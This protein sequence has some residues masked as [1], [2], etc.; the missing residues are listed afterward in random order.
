MAEGLRI[1][2]VC[3]ARSATY[4]AVH[5]MRTLGDAL[6]RGGD[7]VTYVTFRGRGLGAELRREGKR[8]DEFPFRAKL[9]P[10]GVVR[11]A[12]YLRESGTHLV[13]TH[14]STSSVNG[15]AAA[16][17]ARVPVVS[18]VHGLSGKLSF[19]FGDRLLC[20]SRQVADHLRAQGVR[21]RRLAVVYNGI[22]LTRFAVASGRV[23]ARRLGTTAR[24]TPMKGV[25]VALE[26][27]AQL[28]ARYPD[29]EYTVIGE[30]EQRDELEARARVL[31]LA[32]RFHLP[33]YRED[34]AGFLAS[35]D[36]FVFPSLREA[37]GIAI[38]EAMAMGLPV[39]AASVGGVPEVVSEDVGTLV[40]PGDPAALAT[41]IEGYLVDPE[42]RLRAGTN[43]RARVE[44]QFSAEAMASRTREVYLELLAARSGVG[45]VEPVAPRRP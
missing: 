13:H 21:D 19:V 42:R 12:R 28:A 26:A 1:V 11:L 25:P 40:P 5:S 44:A 10:I 14:L 39:V 18:T 9:D 37:M 6:E 17:L 31:G 20:V 41:G 32:D 45:R 27:F 24:L 16:R 43:A 30:G 23:G 3:S 2:Q 8:V 15:G 35:I 29:L 36:L 7:R 38:V 34:V 4:G 33:G 22:D